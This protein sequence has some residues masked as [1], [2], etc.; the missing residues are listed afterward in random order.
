[1]KPI[2]TLLAALASLPA[3]ALTADSL[4]P[5][6]SLDEAPA[7]K[8]LNALRA[9]IAVESDDTVAA[10]LTP[11]PAASHVENSLG[12]ITVAATPVV[13][14]PPIAPTPA[15]VNPAYDPL[16]KQSEW[17]P[18]TRPAPE[19]LAPIVIP[20]GTNNQ[21]GWGRGR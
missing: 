12:T 6:S 17:A 16:L 2:I 5:I 21:S 3:C 11:A 18:E 10:A 14:A 8:T 13:Q 15:A 7:P 4:P 20:S 19:P 9:P 1:M